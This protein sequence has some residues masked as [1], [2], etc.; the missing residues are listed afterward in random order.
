MEYV[1]ACLIGYLLGSVPA[2]LLVARRHGV[3]IANVATRWVLE[4][5]AVAGVIVGARLGEREHRADNLRLFGFALDDADRA[6]IDAAL[7]R[8]TPLA[9]DC[10]DEYRRP[11]FL[12]ASGDLSHHLESLPKI[13][14]PEPVPGRPGRRRT[15]RPVRIIELRRVEKVEELRT[16][17]KL[18]PF[19]PER[20]LFEDRKVDLPRA[21]PIEGVT[22]CVPIL[23]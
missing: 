7:S 6:A 19:F 8:T 16:E 14:T 5:P 12:T 4:Q 3:S 18:L 10:G 2:A 9:G 23:I 15:N 1:A 20:K 17:L 11:P 21:R 13:Y 22:S